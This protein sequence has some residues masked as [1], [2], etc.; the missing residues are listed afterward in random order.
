[1]SLKGINVSDAVQKL[2]VYDVE[3]DLGTEKN[4]V[5]V[6]ADSL[7]K[8]VLIETFG[9]NQRLYFAESERTLEKLHKTIQIDII[10]LDSLTSSIDKTRYVQ[11]L[12]SEQDFLSMS[13]LLI[14][15][16]SNFADAQSCWADLADDFLISPF[17][18]EALKER[19]RIL[20]RSHEAKLKKIALNKNFESEIQKRIM[21]LETKKMQQKKSVREMQ[22][23]W[24]T[25]PMNYEHLCMLF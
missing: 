8:A 23:F 14:T 7:A 1:M 19:I 3:G 11:S 16:E 13:L 17:T 5:W 22:N 10:L 12:K 9:S 15:H 25:Y 24:Q 4:L 21:Q 6:G 18:S 20:I 2:P